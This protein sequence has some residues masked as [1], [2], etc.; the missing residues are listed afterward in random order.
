MP[1]TVTTRSRSLVVGGPAEPPELYDLERDPG[2]STNVW[3]ENVEEGA[4]LFRDAL[5]FLERCGAAE[6]HLEPRRESLRAVACG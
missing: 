2:E 4:R 3:A 5:A 1:I 6:E